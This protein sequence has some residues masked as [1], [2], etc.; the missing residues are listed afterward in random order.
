[1]AAPPAPPVAAAQ[2][3]DGRASSQAPGARMR[4][5]PVRPPVQ[6]APVM[7]PVMGGKAE[8][9]VQPEQ[10]PT[11]PRQPAAPQ[12]PAVQPGAQP[13]PVHRGNPA[14]V[15]R[16]PTTGQAPAALDLR[17]ALREQAQREQQQREQQQRDQ[18]QREQVQREAQQREQ[19]QREQS[20][21]EQAVRERAQR[22]QR[23][24]REGG[25]EPRTE[26][27]VFSAPQAAPA[28][29]QPAPRMRVP[30]REERNEERKPG[31]GR[32]SHPQRESTR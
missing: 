5:Q 7:A 9:M 25:R 8:P 11:A 13:V 29:V 28:V 3:D 22:E 2:G 19:A 27:P 10:R 23:E 30:E 32:N 1:V 14:L 15:E 26:R 6:A 24:Q 31:E 18:Q 12:H 21:R 4:I 16:Q 17:T 20:Q